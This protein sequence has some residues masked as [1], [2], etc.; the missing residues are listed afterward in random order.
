MAITD[1]TPLISLKSW[2]PSLSQQAQLLRSITLLSSCAPTLY[3]TS[4]SLS[5]GLVLPA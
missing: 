2:T 5:E 1:I 4:P 3:L